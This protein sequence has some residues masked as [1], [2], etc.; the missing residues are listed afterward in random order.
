MKT[1]WIIQAYESKTDTGQ[2]LD[3]VTLELFAENEKEAIKKAKKLV[4][5]NFYRLSAVIEK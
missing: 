1:I 5:K 4:K 3:T 2:I